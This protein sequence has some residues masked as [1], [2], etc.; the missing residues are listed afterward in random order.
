MGAERASKHI[1]RLPKRAAH[2]TFPRN[3]RIPQESPEVCCPPWLCVGLSPPW[4][5]F[6]ALLCCQHGAVMLLEGAD[7][8]CTP[9]LSSQD[10]PRAC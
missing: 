6:A 2:Q 9:S 7:S 10:V 1:H 3:E 8:P 4:G 5:S